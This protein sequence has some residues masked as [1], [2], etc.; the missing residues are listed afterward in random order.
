MVLRMPSSPDHVCGPVSPG[1]NENPLNNRDHMDL[2]LHLMLNIVDA[3]M[4]K[5][6]GSTFWAERSILCSVVLKQAQISILVNFCPSFTRGRMQK[7][8]RK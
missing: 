7:F 2:C 4:V 3:Y 5:H 1:L 6:L 8:Q